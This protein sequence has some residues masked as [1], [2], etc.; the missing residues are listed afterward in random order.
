MAVDIL[1]ILSWYLEQTVYE[2]EK[3]AE[4]N[5]IYYYAKYTENGVENIKPVSISDVE[6]FKEKYDI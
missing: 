2:Y 1:Q 4:N 5:T 3:K 6:I